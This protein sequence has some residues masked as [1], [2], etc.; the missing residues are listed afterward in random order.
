LELIALARADGLDVVV[1]QMPLR[2]AY[3][4]QAQRRYPDALRQYAELLGSLGPEVAV[5]RYDRA[6]SLGIQD[7]WFYDYGHM[8]TRGAEVMTRAL[9]ERLKARLAGAR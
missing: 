6:S 4:E 7:R 3:V 5:W 8:T 2:D 9:G 1:V